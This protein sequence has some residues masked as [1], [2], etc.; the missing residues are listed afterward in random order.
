MLLSLHSDIGF[1]VKIGQFALQLAIVGEASRI[2]FSTLHGTAWLAGMRAVTE[3]AMPGQ[4]LD[5]AKAA[6]NL[7]GISPELQLTQA[8][9]IHQQPAASH[10]KQLAARGP[11]S[12]T[13]IGSASTSRSLPLL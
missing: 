6:I 10:N 1:P 2:R 3:A 4:L 9:Q 12:A 11:V 13:V 5:I 8:R 7:L